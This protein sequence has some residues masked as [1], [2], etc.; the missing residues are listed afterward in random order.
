MYV[1]GIVNRDVLF[2]L[3]QRLN[4]INTGSILSRLY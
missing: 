3:K 2:E 1:N 4:E